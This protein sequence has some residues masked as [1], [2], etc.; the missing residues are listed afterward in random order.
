MADADNVQYSLLSTTRFDHALKDV[1][2][3]TR[4]NG[5][6]PSPYMLLPYHFDRLTAA[7]GDH[8]WIASRQRTNYADLVATCDDVVKAARPQYDSTPLRL[9]I[10]LLP[11]GTFKV[12]ATPLGTPC[13]F[14]IPALPEENSV[15]K[16]IYLDSGR[17]SPSIF[18]TTK[19]TQ[20]EPYNAARARVHL[21]PM[22]TAADAHIDVLLR[23]DED[24]LMETSIRNIAF[25]RDSRWITPRVTS[26]CL[27]GVMRRLM[28]QWG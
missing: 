4:V 22:P 5:G 9:R 16:I 19:T 10:L 12:T 14:Y 27:S 7:A 13:G 26:G 18:T 15:E 17:T 21:S 8:G 23:N 1:A 25:L 24:I 2:W 11:D 20:R 6:Q 3:N 28:R